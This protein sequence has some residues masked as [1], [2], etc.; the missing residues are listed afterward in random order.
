MTMSEP[1]G[2]SAASRPGSVAKARKTLIFANDKSSGKTT[3]ANAVLV[4]LLQRY[5][6]LMKSIELRGAVH[7]DQHVT[8]RFIRRRAERGQGR[9]RQRSRGK[10]RTRTAAG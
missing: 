10:P 9:E 3:T 6:I 8:I 2:A 4:S 5:P 1:A 7:P